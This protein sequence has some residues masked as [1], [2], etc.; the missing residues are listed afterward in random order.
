M[1]GER[2]KLIAYWMSEKKI[3][4]LNWTEFGNVCR[5]HGYELI[6]LDLDKPLD[7]QG[8]FV[9][10]LHKLTDIIALANQNHSKSKEL[11]RRIECWINASPFMAVV[12]PLDNVQKLLDRCLSYS[13][14]HK[15]DLCQHGV[16]TPTFAEIVT[17][18]VRETSEVLRQANVQYPFVCKPSVAH[19]SKQ[20][21]KMSII[22]SE[23][24]LADCKPPCVAQTF[25]NHNAVLYKIFIIGAQHYVVERPSLK[26]FYATD[27][28]TIFFDSQDVSKADSRSTLSILDPADILPQNCQTPDQDR[29]SEI[30]NTIRKELGMSLL[31]ID[32]IIENSTGKYAIIDINAYPGYDGFPNFFQ[33]LLHCFQDTITAVQSLNTKLTNSDVDHD[34]GFDTSDSS[35]ERTRLQSQ[36]SVLSMED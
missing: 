34:S 6:M 1:T 5:N 4:K 8:P 30:V 9:L 19:G 29:L 23:K 22:F 3:Q 36:N 26:N 27:R 32:V 7:E 10:F 21:H 17:N 20:A 18:N 35:D 25:I 11:M 2:P 12:D 15:S 31:G 24:Y 33:A 14:V 13:I 16:F 28:P